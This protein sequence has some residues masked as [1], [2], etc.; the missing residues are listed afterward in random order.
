MRFAK[1][2]FILAVFVSVANAIETDIFSTNCS[3]AVSAKGIF[4]AEVGV[5]F[6]HPVY[7]NIV[8]VKAGTDSEVFRTSAEPKPRNFLR[9]ICGGWKLEEGVYYDLLLVYQPVGE[10]VQRL[11]LTDGIIWPSKNLVAKK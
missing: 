3:P 5:L 6:F 9:Q 1:V 2:F 10:K 11:T 7:A 8:L 4:K